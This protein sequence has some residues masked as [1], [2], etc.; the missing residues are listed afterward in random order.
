MSYPIEQDIPI[1]PRGRGGGRPIKYDLDG[2]NI[3]DSIYAPGKSVQ[4]LNEVIAHRKVARGW[5]DR[6]FTV[7]KDGPGARIWRTQ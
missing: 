2:M 6:K 3:G 4:H 5:T 7:R 1:P